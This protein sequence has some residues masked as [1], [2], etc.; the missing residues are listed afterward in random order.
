[1]FKIFDLFVWLFEVVTG[2]YL[3]FDGGLH[4]VVAHPYRM[5]FSGIV[6]FVLALAIL[7]AVGG[8]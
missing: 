7:A 2:C 1:M 6:T 5:V 4:L 3:A 8:A